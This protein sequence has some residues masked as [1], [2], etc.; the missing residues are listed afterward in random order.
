MPP[1]ER[2]KELQRL[3]PER[4]EKIRQQLQRYDQMPQEQKERLQRLW[5]L[6]PGRQ[7]QVRQSM[8]EFTEQPQERRQ[9]MRRKLGQ[10][11]AMSPEERTAYFNS[12]EFKNQFSP[13]EQEIMK[14]MTDVLP[15]R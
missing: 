15:P 2:E 6:P 10:V 1:A 13:G 5:Q 3:P 4:Q 8:R 12:P 11:Q 14:N 7:Q 9:A